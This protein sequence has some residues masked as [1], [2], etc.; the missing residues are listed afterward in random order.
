LQDQATFAQ[1]NSP[2]RLMA[3]AF[4]GPMLERIKLTD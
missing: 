2:A 3:E 1:R 4:G